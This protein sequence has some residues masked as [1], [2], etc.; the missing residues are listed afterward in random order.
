M[1]ALSDAGYASWARTRISEAREAIVRHAVCA[2]TGV[3]LGCGRPGP[4]ATLAAAR[5]TLAHHAH[6]RTNQRKDHTWYGHRQLPM[7]TGDVST[8]LPTDELRAACLTVEA[9]VDRATRQLVGADLPLLHAG[10]TRWSGALTDAWAALNLVY[11]GIAE[12][13]KLP[14]AEP[15]SVRE[16]IDGLA[17]A[18]ADAERAGGV[19]TRVRR[20]LA[21][22]EDRLRRTSGDPAA[23]VAA[24]RWRTAIARLDLV[25]ARLALG[26]RAIDRYVDSLTGT[27]PPPRPRANPVRPTAP[28]VTGARTAATVL[29]SLHPRTG[30][31]GLLARLRRTQSA[32]GAAW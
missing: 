8:P 29:I 11:A 5:R 16:L 4:C 26:A 18:Q 3:C 21:T 9:A 17:A 28:L 6:R 25:A 12:A 32:A 13:R 14:G 19:V 20:Q 23:R 31:R 24:A 1:T 7:M 2:Y 27:A 10:P 30:L 22:A 15:A